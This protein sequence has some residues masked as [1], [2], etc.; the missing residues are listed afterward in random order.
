[1]K[2]RKIAVITSL[3]PRSD[4]R[5]YEKQIMTLK[6]E[7]CYKITFI[8]SDGQGNEQKDGVEQINTTVANMSDLTQQ[9]ASSSEESSAASEELA[10]QAEA[11]KSLVNELTEITSGSSNH[12][13]LES[14]D[15]LLL[16]TQS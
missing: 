12:I 2:S 10:K 5:I 14:G 8:V 6:E 11:L 9:N 3:H 16:E 7:T 13:D 15:K 1:M 4:T